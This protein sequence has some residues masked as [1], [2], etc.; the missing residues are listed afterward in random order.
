MKQFS[1]TNARNMAVKAEIDDEESAEQP[2][3]VRQCSRLLKGVLRPIINT[4]VFSEFSIKLFHKFL[5]LVCFT[6]LRRNIELNI[7]SMTVKANPVFPK[8]NM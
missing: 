6:K 3:S 4:S 1:F 7:I 2:S 5:N 8:G